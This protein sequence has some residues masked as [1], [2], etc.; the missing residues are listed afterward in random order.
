[1]GGLLNE[2]EECD[3]T[4]LTFQDANFEKDVDENFHI[5]FV[6]AASN[7]RAWN[8]RIAQTTRHQCKMIAGKIIPAIATTTASVCGLV[9]VELLKLVQ[10]K[11]LEA[12]KNSSNSLGLNMYMMQE[13][14]EPVHTK[15]EYDPIE[16]AEVKTMPQGFTKWDKMKVQRGP[17]TLQQFIAAFKEMTGLTI[18]LLYHEIAMLFDNTNPT[19]MLQY[20]PVSGRMLYDAAAWKPELA[21]L[22]RSKADTDLATWV[23]ERYEVEGLEVLPKLR[24]Y[25][26]LQASCESADGTPYKIPTLVYYFDAV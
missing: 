12:F 23:C 15:D 16:M 2:L 26:E 19:E 14:G 3:L 25:I 7:L 4:G 13:P 21:D 6:T 17:L 8:Y 18:T 9:M 20:K 22:Y 24:K 1:M 5:D 10:K 11:P